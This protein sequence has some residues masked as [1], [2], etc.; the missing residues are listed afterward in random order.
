MD[1]QAWHACGA[2]HAIGGA[3]QEVVGKMLRSMSAQKDG[4]GMLKCSGIPTRELLFVQ[5]RPCR[6]PRLSLLAGQCGRWDHQH[7]TGRA[8]GRGLGHASEQEAAGSRTTFRAHDDEIGSPLRCFR[9]DFL[10]RLADPQAC[11]H[12]CDLGRASG[13]EALELCACGFHDPFPAKWRKK[14]Q[15]EP[16]Y[17][18]DTDIRR[19]EERR[20]QGDR[21]RMRLRTERG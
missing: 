18:K 20:E 16:D 6:G 2:E 21:P 1:N 12:G 17:P 10:G 11:L 4:A 19:L 3:T 14:R 13:N 9:Y 7:I 5:G 8:S 15:I